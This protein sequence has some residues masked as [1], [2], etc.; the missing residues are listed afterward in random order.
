MNGY[1]SLLILIWSTWTSYYEILNRSNEIVNK[2][3]I[4]PNKENRNSKIFFV[5]K[6]FVYIDGNSLL[7]FHKIFVA[8]GQEITKCRQHWSKKISLINLY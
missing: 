6:R 8:R 1:N 7:L 2:D 5:I 3:M 4:M